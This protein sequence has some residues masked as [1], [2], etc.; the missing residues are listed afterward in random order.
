MSEDR[1]DKWELPEPVFRSSTGELV[2]PSERIEFDPEPDTLDPGFAEQEQDEEIH[3]GAEATPQAADSVDL[4]SLYAP[5]ETAGNDPPATAPPAAP[6]SNIDIEP[7]PQ[8]SEQFTQDDLEIETD[9][10]ER[11]SGGALRTVLLTLLFL[12][13]LGVVGVAGIAAYFYFAGRS[14]TGPF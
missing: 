12:V 13:L 14:L 7:Q 9:V 8:I 6:A 5:V 1:S 3:D 2:K 4:A 11:K 10:P